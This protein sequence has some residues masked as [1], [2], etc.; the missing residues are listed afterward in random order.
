[1]DANVVA[2]RLD[3]LEAL[4]RDEPHSVSDV[5]RGVDGAGVDTSDAS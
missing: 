3:S 1:M 4:D 2:D 5:G